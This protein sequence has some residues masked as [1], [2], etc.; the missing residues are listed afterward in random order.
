MDEIFLIMQAKMLQ[1]KKEHLQW[2][3][4]FHISHDEIVYI[5]ADGSYS[6]VH[7]RDGINI[8]TS[9]KLADY[10][11]LLT[12]DFYRIHHATIVNLKW[13]SH[14]DKANNMVVLTND[15]QLPISRRKKS[16]FKKLL[17][18]L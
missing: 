13:V 14:L 2:T 17:L 10:E 12:E 4:E 6:T 5:Q 9:K 11:R 7:T 3:S 16:D 15:D 8:F 1:N 18:E